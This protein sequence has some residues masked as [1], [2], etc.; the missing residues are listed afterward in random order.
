MIAFDV[1][2]DG[3]RRRLTEV[4]LDYGERV[5][6]SVFWI[7]CDDEMRERLEERVRKTMEKE[8]DKVWILPLCLGCGKRI[9]VLG[10][11]R[12]PEMPEYYIE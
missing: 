9:V 7:E 8:E 2:D 1:C 4:L 6:E 12:K 11:S 10:Q 3:R 5:Q